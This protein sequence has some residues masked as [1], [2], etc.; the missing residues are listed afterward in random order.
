MVVMITMV[1][2]MIMVSP[3]AIVVVLMV[4]MSLV[5]L[6]AFAVVVIMRMSPVGPFIR[7]AVPASPN[8]PV[9]VTNRFPISFHPDEAWT[10][11]R[12]ILLIADRRWRGSDVHRN[13]C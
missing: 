7:R 4:P 2:I 8:P 11:S 1:A 3:V 12:S 10:W 13:L 6:P 5:H 9:M